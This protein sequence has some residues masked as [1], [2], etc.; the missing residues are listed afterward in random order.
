MQDLVTHHRHTIRGPHGLGKTALAAQAVLWFAL[1]RD[2]E[3]WKVPTLAS[4]WRQLTKFL[5]PEIR[6]W[7]RRLK[8]DI[9]GREPFND[10]EMLIEGLKL[11]TGEAFAIASD[12][13]AFIEGAHAKHILYVFDESK[14]IPDDTWDAAEGAM[15]SGEAYWLAISTPGEPAGRFYDIHS[16]KRGYDDWHVKHVTLDMAIAAGRVNEEWARKRKEQWGEESAAYQNHV[17]GE[18]ASSDEDSLISL[19]DVERA[20][21]RWE[22]LNDE[23]GWG[24][25]TGLGVDIGRGGDPSAFAYRH[26]MAVR[27]IEQMHVADTMQP[28]GRIVAVLRENSKVIATIDV[29]GLGAGV[30]DRAREQGY[31]NQLIPF[32]AGEKTT[33]TDSSGE[34]QFVDLRSAGWWTLRELLKDPDGEIALPP[35]DE[36]IGDL[37]APKWREM[38]NGR[39]RVES[40]DDIKK[41]LKRSTNNGDAVMMTFCPSNQPPKKTV[42]AFGRRR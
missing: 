27:R 6:K 41:R 31:K 16:R 14:T 10:R 30:Y 29:I 24:A 25:L 19:A 17:A 11:R 22:I 42:R 38:S 12:N 33:I 2:G 34:M 37:T 35:D 5:W 9:I 28:T 4:K 7:S 32:V 26:G 18:F 20:N 15:A 3:D 21:T 23:N 1:T 36:L 40:K 8:W 13:A 39:V